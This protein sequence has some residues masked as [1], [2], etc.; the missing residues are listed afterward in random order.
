MDWSS[1]ND[2]TASSASENAQATQQVIA[3]LIHDFLSPLQVRS[4]INET[5]CTK[6]IA[7][8][9]ILL[10]LV[11]NAL[12]AT[13]ITTTK[14][15]I[16]TTQLKHRK[17]RLANKIINE[18]VVQQ[19]GA[20]DLLTAVGFIYDDTTK[21]EEAH[22]IFSPNDE[23]QNANFFIVTMQE[24]LSAF[25]QKHQQQEDIAKKSKRVPTNQNENQGDIFLSEKER[26]ERR[27]KAKKAKKAKAEERE[28][29]RLRWMEDE[30]NRREI[31]KRK[32]KKMDDRKVNRA[33]GAEG[34][35][36]SIVADDVQ[37]MNCVESNESLQS[38]RAKAQANWK[39]RCGRDEA[40]ENIDKGNTVDVVSPKPQIESESSLHLNPNEPTKESPNNFTN[41]STSISMD[42]NLEE[43]QSSSWQECL[44]NIPRCGPSQN[45]RN[46]SVFYKGKAKYIILFSYL[47]F[48]FNLTHS[49]SYPNN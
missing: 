3:F 39:K 43:D 41:P 21:N 16:L 5:I 18:K 1:T 23:G 34:E 6:I 33:G 30:D 44:R 14:V 37:K 20:M 13:T 27:I 35:S 15:E 12:R 4:P 36:I 10:K 26:I 11:Q 49:K 40:M 7:S 29:A 46:S 31:R 45:I 48:C 22:L 8:A 17:I 19:Q 2:P 25:Q 38:L 28:L 47:Y 32:E 24:E 9:K 42:D